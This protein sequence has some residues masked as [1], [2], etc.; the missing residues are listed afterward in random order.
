M[1]FISDL[2]IS[3]AKTNS[4]LC[5]G[6]DPILNKIPAHLQTKKDFIFLFNKLIIDSTHNLVCCY[7]PNI[8]FYASEGIY[9]LRQLEKTIQYLHEEYPGTAVIL[10]AK[11]GDIGTTAAQYAREAFEVYKA[12]ATTVNP[13]LG[14]DSIEPYLKYKDK[15][16]IIL[17][18]TSNR[19]AA[20]FQDLGVYPSNEVRSLKPV[21]VRQKSSL[22]AR[23]IKPLY[24]HIAK[25]VLS[26]NKRYKNCL[27]VVGATWP[28]QLKEIRGIAP[29]MFFLIPGI[30]TQGGD[31][32]ATIASGIRKDGSG[33]IISA[34][35]SVLYAESGKNFAEAAR[36][37][38]IKLRDTINTYR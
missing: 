29:D 1:G 9:G 22:E 8:A 12:D 26:W 30:G 5:I 15:G 13:F 37:E 6:L 32:E 27:L 16:V 11:R 25:Q 14:F 23:T 20:D 10:D 34:S 7:K 2:E 35:R 18:R 33:L 17:C 4:L 36:I 31:I 3:I 28:E 38:T 24:Y 19:G 21:T